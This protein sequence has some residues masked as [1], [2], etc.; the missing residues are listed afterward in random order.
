MDS[1]RT[2]PHRAAR[3]PPVRDETDDSDEIISDE[4][5]LWKN[6]KT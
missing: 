1:R 2:N 5:I 6:Y 3:S 4:I